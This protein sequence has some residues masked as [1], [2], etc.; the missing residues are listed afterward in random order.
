MSP[1]IYAGLPR[2]RQETYLQSKDP[3][4][5]KMVEITTK[6]CKY[7][8]VAMSDVISPLR[9]AP[10][11]KAR[12]ISMWFIKKNERILLR[13]IGYFFGGRDHSTVLYSI[14]TV[15]DLIDTDRVYKRTIENISKLL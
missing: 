15:Q 6:V 10:T 11:I 8:R 14:D 4:E 7:F 9:D 1:E 13:Q 12:Q 2:I 3:I 5:L